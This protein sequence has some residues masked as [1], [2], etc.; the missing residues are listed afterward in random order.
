M[1]ME[2]IKSE[3]QKKKW[4]KKSEQIYLWNISEQTYALWEKE[5]RKK[6]QRQ[7]VWRN[8]GWKLSKFEER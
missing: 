7:N 6:E 4:L 2:I 5:K 3:K 1:T 8:N